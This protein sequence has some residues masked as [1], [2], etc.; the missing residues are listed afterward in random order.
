MGPGQEPDA[1]SAAPLK[2]V[3]RYLAADAYRSNAEVAKLL[4]KGRSLDIT[5]SEEMQIHFGA[6]EGIISS[7][8][9][10]T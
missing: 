7:S 2:A 3:R 5:S 9:F 1:L 10:P 4:D 6:D 8:S